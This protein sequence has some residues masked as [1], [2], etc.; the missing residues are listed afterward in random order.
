M[1]LLKIDEIVINEHAYLSL[2]DNCYY[3]A[4]YTSGV[5][6]ES[7][8]P[9]NSLILNFK[10]KV[11]RRELSDWRYKQQAINIIATRLK[12]IILRKINLNDIILVPIPPSKAKN[13]PMYDDRM[14]RV[15]EAASEGINNCDIRELI[16]R[17]TSSPATHIDGNRL[18]PF[19]LKE[20][21]DLDLAQE[22]DLKGNIILFDDVVTTGAHFVACKTL[23]K[24]KYPNINVAGVFIAR[25]DRSLVEKV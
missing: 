7:K 3:L 18:P 12:E 4:N 2:R 21:F 25:V 24:E 11:D 16:I 9:I 1:K 19:V 8:N 23:I 22:S 6:Y 10:K 15:L 13:D 14:T 20:C 5:G 17:N